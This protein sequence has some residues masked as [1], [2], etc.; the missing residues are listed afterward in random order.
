MVNRV[1][2][3]WLRMFGDDT[4]FFSDNYWDLLTQ[5]WR[6]ER[7]V[8]KTDALG[9]LIA[10]KSTHTAGKY[11]ERTIEHGIIIEVDN[12]DDARSRLISLSPDMR[13]R[14][15]HFFDTAVD[16]VG[17]THAALKKLADNN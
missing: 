5:L 2:N 8:R 1:G 3:A 9:Y 15:D 12:P 7:P 13:A 4:E 14:L 11:L 16:E 17:H 6:S 10:V